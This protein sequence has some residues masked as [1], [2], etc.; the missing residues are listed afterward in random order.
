MLD[1]PI[2]ALARRLRRAAPTSTTA[3]PTPLRLIEAALRLTA[4][5]LYVATAT[6][7]GWLVIRALTGG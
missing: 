5:G 4:L 1:T 2:T 7:G 3:P 6:L